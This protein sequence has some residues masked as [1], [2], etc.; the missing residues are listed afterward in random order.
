MGSHWQQIGGWLLQI[1]VI[2]T[3]VLGA[4]AVGL[5]GMR[6]PRH[7]HR[8]AASGIVAVVLAIPLSLLPS[9][10]NVETPRW[11]SVPATPDVPEAWEVQA[12]PDRWI[13]EDASE[14][15]PVSVEIAPLADR[16]LRFVPLLILFYA[17][18]VLLALSRL[19]VGYVGLMRLRQGSKP[20]L[21]EWAV[22]AIAVDTP[23]AIRRSAIRSFAM[24]IGR[25]H[26]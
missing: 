26:V 10:W 1:A 5:R 4:V 6:S 14:T 25:A 15:V 11:A 8:L 18:C 3:V 20:L 12:E 16:N 17:A 13:R 19:L 7:R 23:T 21:G 22:I 24:K 9:W 2:G